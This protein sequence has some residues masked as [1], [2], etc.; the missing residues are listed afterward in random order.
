MNK[1]IITI[2]FIGVVIYYL[3]LLFT[4]YSQDSVEG[5]VAY[6]QSRPYPMTHTEIS[7]GSIPL[8]G[9]AFY[10]I[11]RNNISEYPL[12]LGRSLSFISLIIICIAIKKC[13][14]GSG[15]YLIAILLLLLQVPLLRFGVVNRP[16]MPALALAFLSFVI[17]IK[18]G[19]KSLMLIVPL[20]VISFFIKQPAPIA[21]IASVGT[22][23]LHRK[24]YR[25][26]LVALVAGTILVAIPF[27]LSPVSWICMIEANQNQMGLEFG[28]NTL[29]K[30][31]PILFLS[32]LFIGNRDINWE[33][34]L[35][36]IFSILFATIT[37]FKS[38]SN[39]NYFIETSLAISLIV[40]TITVSKYLWSST[41]TKVVTV[42]L[43]FSVYTIT[44][45]LESLKISKDT[46]TRL[47]Q[48]FEDE[49]IV[50]FD[51]TSLIL[52]QKNV[53][54][55]DLHI[56]NQLWNSSILDTNEI[57]NTVVRA[58]TII[59]SNSDEIFWPNSILPKT[60]R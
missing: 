24:K 36:L 25:E 59:C 55:P 46:I 48:N 1:R 5:I 47:D 44:F 3:F 9:R 7:G 29:L 32:M 2:V 23:L 49:T 14:Y 35:Y 31:I 50:Q 45:S 20:L 16:D 41:F 15:S 54:I 19:E 8:Y 38:G 11:T 43:I 33:F 60:R 13:E 30:V 6:H 40:R 22:I 21:T 27:L 51:C 39:S 57:R 58:D 52:A 56:L 18:R 4:P 17:F 28:I 53:V 37:S 10:L 42:L 12:L 34:R 26:S